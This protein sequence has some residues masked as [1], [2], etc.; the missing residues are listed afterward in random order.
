[1]KKK[2]STE[3][4]KRSTIVSQGRAA[5]FL[6]PSSMV[7]QIYRDLGRSIA[8]GELPP[9]MILK[10][11]ELQKWFGVS[12]APIRE[13]IRLLE[14]NGLVVVDAYKKKFVRHVTRE[15]LKEV[16][17][18]VALLEGHAAILAAKRLTVE[19]IDTLKNTNEK[20]QIAYDQGRYD[21]C[22]ELNSLFHKTYINAANNQA[23]RTALRSINKGV[24]FLW[25]ANFVYGTKDFVPLAISEHNMI[26]KEF[27]KRDSRR[28][29]EAVRTHIIKGLER[30]IKGEAF[31]SNGFL[32]MQKGG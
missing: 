4:T 19:Q 1:M 23:I 15:Y 10:E 11:T 21:L 28:A 12:R 22:S 17:P 25:V 7:D 14:A 8:K 31:D 16:I 30:P 3:D 13:A 26:I 20:M 6:K 24:I 5:D 27:V 18:V 29:D 2:K 9:G 32:V